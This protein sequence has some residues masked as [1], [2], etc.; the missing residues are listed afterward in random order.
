MLAPTR[1]L[2]GI[3]TGGRA[4]D[5]RPWLN[6]KT[7]PPESGYAAFKARVSWG[8]SSVRTMQMPNLGGISALEQ[9]EEGK[10]DRTRDVLSI[11][12]VNGRSE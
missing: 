7:P 8:S 11:F 3:V 10:S 2:S 9:V 6:V 4:A 12:S 5:D 1:H